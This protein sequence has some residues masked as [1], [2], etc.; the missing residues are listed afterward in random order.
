ML[1]KSVAAG[2]TG[3]HDDNL[4]NTE[5]EVAKQIAAFNAAIN[6]NSRLNTYNYCM[7]GRNLGELLK[8]G[9]KGKK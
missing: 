1:K 4:P 8:G 5:R 6:S 3:V 2:S 9:K 7:I